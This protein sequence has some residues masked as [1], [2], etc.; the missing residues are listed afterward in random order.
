MKLRKGVNEPS[1]GGLDVSG[2]QSSSSSS[3]LSFIWAFR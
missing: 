3:S 1:F 2:E